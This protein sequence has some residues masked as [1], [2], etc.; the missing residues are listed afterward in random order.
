MTNTKKPVQ[1]LCGF[2]HFHTLLPYSTNLSIDF[3]S[4][5]HV[6]F[7]TSSAAKSIDIRLNN[8][9]L[10]NALNQQKPYTCNF[11]LTKQLQSSI[12]KVLHKG[13]KGR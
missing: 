13:S 5:Y 10:F 3:I 7:H 1:H 2:L 12:L 9:P 4:S 8:K 6:T 11:L